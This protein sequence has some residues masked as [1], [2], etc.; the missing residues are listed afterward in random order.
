MS[1]LRRFLGNVKTE[2]FERLRDELSGGEYPAAKR[3]YKD[4]KSTFGHDEEFL[5][6]L[7]EIIE[8]YKKELDL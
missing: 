3:I 6:E 7:E 8:P 2:Y 5:R 4:L 1:F